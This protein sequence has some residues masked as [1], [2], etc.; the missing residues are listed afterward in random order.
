MGHLPSDLG[1]MFLIYSP[2]GFVS[3]SES[4]PEIEV[5]VGALLHESLNCLSALWRQGA[6]GAV[7]GQGAVANAAVHLK[8]VVLLCCNISFLISGVCAGILS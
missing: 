6:A 4:V 8:E 1:S 3:I 5:A 2:V 7:V